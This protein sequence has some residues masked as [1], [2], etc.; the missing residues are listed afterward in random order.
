MEETQKATDELKQQLQHWLKEYQVR[1]NAT[2]PKEK[3]ITDIKL[4]S[5]IKPVSAWGIDYSNVK[6]PVKVLEDEQV[7]WF[8]EIWINRKCIFRQTYITSAAHKDLQFLAGFEESLLR[9]IT[10]EIAFMGLSKA[11]RIIDER[12][13]VTP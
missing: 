7:G 2:Q 10:D 11:Q 4:F 3:M 5:G 1:A 8:V 13:K 12:D 6:G 9:A